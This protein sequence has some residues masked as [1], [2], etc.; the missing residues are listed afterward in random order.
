MRLRE[1]SS[2]PLGELEYIKINHKKI[3]II[4]FYTNGITYYITINSKIKHTSLLI[5][6]IKRTITKK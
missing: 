6:K 5:N 3:S 2:K 1:T 4:L